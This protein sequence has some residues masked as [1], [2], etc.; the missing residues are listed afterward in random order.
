M[1]LV[2]SSWQRH[3]ISMP[4]CYHPVP[5]NNNLIDKLNDLFLIP[6]GKKVGGNKQLSVNMNGFYHFGSCCTEKDY[7]K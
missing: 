1:Q 5:N 2:Q 6:Q 3:W 4:I 7:K